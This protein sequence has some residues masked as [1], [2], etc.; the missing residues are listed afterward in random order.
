M[1]PDI[2]TQVAVMADPER[3]HVLSLVLDHSDAGFAPES[4]TDA[5]ER[6]A[7]RRHLDAMEGAGLVQLVEGRYRPTGAALVHFGAPLGH[8]GSDHVRIDVGEHERI[9]GTITEEL[10]ARHHGTLAPE[11]VHAF[12]LESYQLLASRAT[13]RRHLPQ[14]T[15]RFAADRLSALASI[16]LPGPAADVLFVCVRNAGRSQ[17][18][19]ALM[20]SAAGESVRIRTAGSAPA[21]QVDPVV[22]AEL[23]RLGVGQLTEFPR[24][25]TDE[26][27]RAS[28]VVVTMGCGDACPVIP[29]PRYVDWEVPDPVG[30]P[31]HEVRGII[32]DIRDRVGALLVELGVATG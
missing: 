12:V 17:I 13:V 24:P 32:S 5:G 14:L 2:L 25:L 28:A 11:T 16:Q 26:V 22:G 20:R 8:S 3:L 23:T 30:R 6:D 10:V 1:W 21:A 7:V 18:A 9:L 19:A 4:L 31:A 15:A 27:V 29:G